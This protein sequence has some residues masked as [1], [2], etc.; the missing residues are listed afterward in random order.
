[1]M[2]PAIAGSRPAWK[3]SEPS[4]SSSRL[5]LRRA[6]LHCIR[7]AL[8][9]YENFFVLGP[10]TPWRLA[11]HLS[12][13]Y[14]FSRHA[15]DLVDENADLR[16]AARHLADWRAELRSCLD[17]NPNHPITRALSF[18]VDKFSLPHQLLSDLLSAFEQDLTV[19]R[20]PTFDDLRNYTRRSADPVGRLVLRL[21]G[22]NDPELDAMS[23]S[24]CTGLQ[25]ANFC[26]DVGEDAERNRIYIPLDECGRFDVDYVEILDRI[27]SP[28]LER[29]LHFQIVRAYRF[30]VAGLPLAERL[31]GRLKMTV[32]LF[33]I[34]GLQILDNLRLNPL[35][36]LHRR[37]KLSSRQR[38]SALLSS[39]R[40]IKGWPSPGRSPGVQPVPPKL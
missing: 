17:G 31:R 24:I 2:N 22:C 34:G 8:S 21:Y 23:D 11:P 36:A 32:R 9:H 14:A 19:T 37:V 6:Q 38:V 35:L 5:R 25:L 15:D 16:E 7:T 30:L 10:L 26:Q 40:P 20:Y 29:L 39:L 13:L 1:M 18:T 33:A 28:R 27:P 4:K 3:K 12:A